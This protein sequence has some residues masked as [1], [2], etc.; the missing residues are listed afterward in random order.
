MS[1]FG[2]SPPGSRDRNSLFAEFMSP[3]DAASN[4]L[5]DDG[6]DAW[7]TGAFPSPRQ[8]GSRN[9]EDI[10]KALIT[11]ENANVPEEYVHIYDILLN[12]YGL[13]GGVSAEGV[14]AVL[15]E[16]MVES[17]IRKRIL[18][19][20]VRGRD[21][22][23]REEVN[24]LLAM[25]GLAQE[26]DDVSIDG[27]DD[28]R[29]NL[30][31]PILKTIVPSSRQATQHDGNIATPT[32]STASSNN[33]YNQIVSQGP[34][35]PS[36][37]HNLP[38]SP[39]SAKP[40]IVHRE[41]STPISTSPIRPRTSTLFGNEN[42][43][44]DPWGSP[45]LPTNLGNGSAANQ[46]SRG[47]LV[48]RTNSYTSPTTSKLG[49]AFN[50]Q[51][52]IQPPKQTKQPQSPH[53]K[54]IYTEEEEEHEPDDIHSA[55]RNHGVN[56]NTV[57]AWGGYDTNI[58]TTAVRNDSFGNDN[59]GHNPGGFGSSA[60]TEVLGRRASFGVL[61][62]SSLNGGAI[63]SNA[64]GRAAPA[65]RSVIRGPEETVTVTVLP[66]KEGM[67][68]FQHRNYQIASLRR[69]TRVVR[70]YSDFVWL[71]E[72]LHKRYPFRQLPLLPP[73][74]LAVNGHYLSADAGFLERRRRG[75][76]RFTNALVRHPVLSQET[77][78]VMFLTVPTE[79]ELSVWRKQTTVQIMEEFEGK[80]MPLGLE[81]SLPKDL[82]H[83]FETVRAGL[84]KSAEIYIG[85]CNLVER[86]EKRHEGVA[87]D[88]FRLT[89]ALRSLTDA[90]AATY[91]VDTND[92]PLLNDGLAAVAKHYGQSQA[93]LE[94]ESKAWDSGVLE[95]LKRQRDCLVSMR[96]M[97]DRKDRLAGNNIPQL[98]RAI[99]LNERKISHLEAKPKDLVK[100]GEIEKLRE[101]IKRDKESIVRQRERGVLIRV[102]VRDELVFFQNSQYHIS[103]LQ[104]DWAQERVKYAELQAD[105]WKALCNEVEAMPTGE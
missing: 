78:V 93:L 89:L 24:V 43:S 15:E 38:G 6:A 44:D 63:G 62:E 8:P 12:R 21:K 35:S 30:P 98:E 70:R 34:Q 45:P 80:Q 91:A 40:I 97:F 27:V 73:K 26:G 84:R 33:P 56:R 36:S 32:E 22:V 65:L 4:S 10:I 47:P 90:S 67:F 86:L 37:A 11:T 20:V 42:P 82:N 52:T 5:F 1:L 100:P 41:H 83:I 105:N 25:V 53:P 103:R 94:D 13:D 17:T 2:E 51:P 46:E 81:E 61:G 14:R 31:I 66:E 60:Q 58:S 79:K 101:S 92:V 68:M 64:N 76:V 48:E 29:K 7:S 54:S 28:R 55:L 39:A 16:A 72:C 23:W 99:E 50:P 49:P 85:L 96:E 3:A 19:V 59:F 18:E 77:L 104:Q 102:C 75:L 69:G 95:D 71:L 57:N 88:Y 87:A 9:P 74:R